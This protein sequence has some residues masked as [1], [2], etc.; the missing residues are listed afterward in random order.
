MGPYPPPFGGVSVHIRRLYQYLI[1]DNFNV[2]IYSETSVKYECKDFVTISDF[3]KW[4]LNYFISGKER[5]FHCHTHSWNRR[6]FISLLCLRRKKVIF[7]FHSLRNEWSDLSW[8]KKIKIK[9][10]LAIAYKIIVVNET[11]FYKLTGW[12]CNPSKIEII[13]AYIPPMLDREDSGVPPV[14]KEFIEDG[15]KIIVSNASKLVLYKEQDLYGMDMMVY[16]TQKLKTKFR[17]IRTIICLGEIGD[18]NYFEEINAL[19]KRLNIEDNLKIVIGEDLIPILSKTHL[20]IRPSYSDSYGVSIAEAIYM[21]VPAIASDVCIRPE[22]TV[23]FKNRDIDDLFKK[24]THLIEEYEYHKNKIKKI[25][26]EINL[27]RI[28]TVYKNVI[29]YRKGKFIP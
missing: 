12:G 17:K 15:D 16:L 10:L 19:V 7:T 29:H 13:N 24:A 5:I 27:E 26:P 23:L 9:M 1:N 14:L 3:S 8:K 22:G 11:L 25:K 20:F 6:F 21:K 2:K 4:F 28:K 18:R